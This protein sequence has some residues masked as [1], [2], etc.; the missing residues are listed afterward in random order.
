MTTRE[1][2]P[3]TRKFK[4]FGMAIFAALAM[5]VVSA[6]AAQAEK[7]GEFR[8]GQT[9]ET[10]THTEIHGVQYG[11]TNYFEAFGNKTECSTATYHGTDAD[12]TATQIT[13]TPVYSGCLAGGL[14]S[15]V[16]TNGCEFGFSQPTTTPSGNWTSEIH[17]TCPV[18][19]QVEVHAYSGAAHGFTLCTIKIPPQT[20]LDHAVFA[21]KSEG[22][23][24][25]LTAELTVTNITATRTGLCVENDVT[26]TSTA[27]FQSNVT[28]KAYKPTGSTPQH[29]LWIAHVN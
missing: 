20:G 4:A 17:L 22:G 3:M 18:G 1:G 9:P 27:T 15:T 28:V 24:D 26:H 7:K 23:K 19:K 13:V 12:G 5:A 16:T 21:Q 8:A 11:A 2:R 6:P 10:H 25:H 29:D 14:P